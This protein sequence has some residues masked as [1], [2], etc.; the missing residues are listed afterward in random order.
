MTV[1]AFVVSEFRLTVAMVTPLFSLIAV[2]VIDSVSVAVSL[3]VICRLPVPL[4]SPVAA[5]VTVKVWSPS[6]TV[7]STAV[8]VN[9]ADG[10]PAGMTT[11]AGTVASLVS[12]PVKVTVS[13]AVVSVLRVTV[14]V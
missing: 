4:A 9:V 5:A 7:S 12:S 6:A 3:S 1:K 14:P 10:W 11:L 2:S 8:I 13:S